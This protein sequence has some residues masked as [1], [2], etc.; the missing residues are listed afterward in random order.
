MS[1]NLSDL[2]F[3]ART[4]EPR[5]AFDVL[6]AGDYDVV[7]VNTEKKPTKAGDGAYLELT[8]QVCNGPHQNR[9][10]FDRLHLWNA[11]EK[12]VAIARGTLSAICRAVNRLNP[13]DSVE[14]HNLPG[15]RCK[16]AVKE[17]QQRGKYNEVK[18]YK[19][20]HTQAAA[21]QVGPAPSAPQNPQLMTGQAA[22]QQYPTVP[23]NPF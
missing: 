11:S 5:S 13:G 7:I 8:L 10:L 20:R 18:G 9:K 1:G 12:A 3:D 23:A 6:P 16:V 4:T 2:G 15:L 14:L 17:D 19:D 21:P 22:P